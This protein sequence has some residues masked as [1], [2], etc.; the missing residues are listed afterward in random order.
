MS[1]R[2]DERRQVES[3]NYK[4][5]WFVL[6]ERCRGRMQ[7]VGQGIIR[8]ARGVSGEPANSNIHY[9]SGYG[10]THSAASV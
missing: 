6:P 3:L 7:T 4:R 2:L 5:R 10:Y 8:A 9:G 1:I